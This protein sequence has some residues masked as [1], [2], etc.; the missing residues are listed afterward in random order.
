MVG[1][2]PF[3]ARTVRRS[4]L[5]D[6]AAIRIET[7][8]KRLDEQLRGIEWHIARD[9][10]GGWQVRYSNLYLIKTDPWPDAPALR[11]YYTIDDDNYCTLQ[12]IEFIEL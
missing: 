9:A 1:P 12:W 3:R 7:D 8:A 10:E 2:Q 4:A 6:E 11:V 5:F